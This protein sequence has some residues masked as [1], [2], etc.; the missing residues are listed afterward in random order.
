[1]IA[2]EISRNGQVLAVAGAQDLVGLYT[3]LMACGDL[4]GTDGMSHFF[5]NAIGHGKGPRE[6]TITN[7]TW[8]MAPIAGEFQ[9]GDTLS[10]R[11]IQTDS[12]TLPTT[13]LEIEDNDS[14]D[15]EAEQ[16]AT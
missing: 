9:V 13:S 4:S 5:V 7:H 10:I 2:F 12:P 6:N 8:D 15:E 3:T 14:E 11:V 16:A 1:M